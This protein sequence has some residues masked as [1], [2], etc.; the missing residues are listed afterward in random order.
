MNADT[1]RRF[2]AWTAL[3]LTL[4]VGGVVCVV[5]GYYGKDWWTSA[6]GLIAIALAAI[7]RPSGGRKSEGPH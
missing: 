4:L 1:P 7:F 5:M 2:A 3:R 6:L